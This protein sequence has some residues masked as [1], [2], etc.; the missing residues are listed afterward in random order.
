MTKLKTF[1]YWQKQSLINYVPVKKKKYF[2]KKQSFYFFF[3]KPSKSKTF[4]ISIGKKK[5]GIFFKVK[6]NYSHL[7]PC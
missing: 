2:P 1:F 6:K 5:L 3:Q 7:E 4:F